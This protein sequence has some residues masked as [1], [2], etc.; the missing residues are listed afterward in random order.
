MLYNFF[1]LS[2]NSKFGINDK[3]LKLGP[4]LDQKVEM[5]T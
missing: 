4:N 5:G 2:E 1:A 3:I